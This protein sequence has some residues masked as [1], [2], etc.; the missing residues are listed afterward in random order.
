[1]VKILKYFYFLLLIIFEKTKSLIEIKSFNFK[2]SKWIILDNNNYLVCTEK[3]I[4]TYDYTFED[5]IYNITFE[6]EITTDTE[7]SFISISKILNEE[8]NYIIIL[9]RKFFYFLKSYGELIFSSSIDIYS[10]NLEYY[11]LIPYINNNKYYFIVPSVTNDLKFRFYLFEINIF[12]KSLIESI[13][14]NDP[15]ENIDIKNS[16]FSRGLDCV[17]MIY[18]SDKGV[19]TCFHNFY[20]L[21]VTSFDIENNFTIISEL[22]NLFFESI[23][24]RTIKVEI[25]SGKNEALI[26]FN[27]DLVDLGN[28]LIYYINYHNF[29]EIIESINCNYYLLS[30]NLI[31]I[32]ITKEFI[33]SC[34]YEN[35]I[36]ISKF[37]EHFEK[38]YKNEKEEK[39]NELKFSYVENINTFS[40]IY[41]HEYNKY[42]LTIS[43]EYSN[44]IFLSKIYT[45]SNKYSPNIDINKDSSKIIPFIRLLSSDINCLYY[46]E[47]ECFESIP[48]GYYLLNESFLNKC[49]DDCELCNDGPINNNTNCNK[50]K[51]NTKYLQKGNCVSECDERFIPDEENNCLPK[52][53]YYY[54]HYYDEEKREY[55]FLEENQACPEQFFFENIYKEC[56]ELCSD[57]EYLNHKCIIINV[58]ENNIEQLNDIMKFFFFELMYMSISES[59]N[60]INFS[61]EGRNVIIQVVSYR[62]EKKTNNINL[63]KIDLGKCETKLKQLHDIPDEEDLIIY[64]NIINS[65]DSLYNNFIVN[66]EIY[67]PLTLQQLNLEYCENETIIIYTPYNTFNETSGIN[68]SFIPECPED[69]P[70]LIKS[71]NECTDN[72]NIT[73]LFI[74]ECILNNPDGV[75]KEDISNKIINAIN[76]TELISLLDEVFNNNE[77]FLIDFENIKYQ[78]TS[79]FNQINNEDNNISTINLGKCENILKN[80]Y[81]ISEDEPLLIFK[82]DSYI[83]GVLIP[84][85]MYEVYHPKTKKKLD[86]NHCEDT[87]ITINLPCSVDENELFKHDPSNE[88]YNDICSSYTQ[89]GC[90]ITLKDRQKEFINNNYTLCEDGCSFNGYEA[91]TKKVECNCN[92][93]KAMPK[94]SEIK[95]DREKLKNNFIN[96]KRIINLDIMKCYK[97]LFTK[98]GLLKNV[99]SYILLSI[100]FIHILLFILFI[101]KECDIIKRKINSICL[102]KKK[103]RINNKQNK[104][105]KQKNGK[106][107]KAKKKK[108]FKLKN[109]KINII[110]NYI[111]NQNSKNGNNTKYPPKKK[112]AKVKTKYNKNNKNKIN[113][114]KLT[115][116]SKINLRNSIS[117]SRNINNLITINNEDNFNPNKNKNNKKIKNTIMKYT[118]YELNSMTFKNA[119]AYDKRSY[120]QYYLSLLRTKHILISAIMPSYDYNSRISKICLFLFSFTLYYCI[121]A[122]FF[123]DNIIHIITE[124]DGEFNFIYQLPQILY[125]SI[126]SSFISMLI[127]YLSLFEK[128]MLKFKNS[129]EKNI[130]EDKNKLMKFLRMKFVWF[131][132]ISLAFLF[133]FWYYLSCFCVVNKNSHIHLLKDTLISFGFSLIY[134]FGIYLIP[135]IFRITSL[136]KKSLCLYRIDKITQMI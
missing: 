84:V 2:Y 46:Y 64:K 91:K 67:H 118:D 131:F 43:L 79:T 14:E 103:F 88:F 4:Y 45:L 65:T 132:N 9:C 133:L 60:E 21:G 53:Y 19:L 82:G 52:N 69:F 111:I 120:I 89:N 1:M 72:C 27:N 129:K 28:C 85:V 50:C 136:K 61:V 95:I 23:T 32:E 51:D 130:E 81:N 33:F 37:N 29:S 34:N 6:D 99:S 10:S 31:Y 70:F 90:D 25:N 17:I 40:I 74:Q 109:K 47:S 78:I 122:I 20:N 98:E 66:Y 48:D 71:K 119:L 57:E 44:N 123:T 128:D 110:Q 125:S 87:Q 54:H 26:C 86:L 113:M 106:K 55:I 102:F 3:G 18:N 94:A 63:S 77:D 12:S 126:I 76:S 41:S 108:V 73:E 24:P 117:D 38:I 16:S 68:N 36:V 107:N 30:M 59:S 39:E 134:P 135:G 115:S 100:I 83:E 13:Y 104:E 105:E 114:N 22:N 93:K 58:N 75:L 127:R 56:K 80:V 124:D 112:I 11:S 15:L 62:V 97:K 5:L 116:K 121:N 35:E 96:I 101:L 8:E 7:F 92:I 49:H 42:L